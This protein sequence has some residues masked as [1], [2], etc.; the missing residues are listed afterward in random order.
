M[1]KDTKLTSIEIF[2][3]SNKS[4]FEDVYKNTLDYYMKSQ[5]NNILYQNGE[6]CLLANNIIISNKLYVNKYHIIEKNKIKKNKS[7]IKIIVEILENLGGGSYLIKTMQNNNIYKLKQDKSYVV[8]FNLLKKCEIILLNKIIDYNNKNKNETDF[9]SDDK[10]IIDTSEEDSSN[11]SKE[12][13]DLE[14]EEDDNIHSEKLLFR[15]K[16]L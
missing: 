13:T 14:I 7:F 4:I 5:K 3:G 2:F 12:L 9:K 15:S 11:K 8:N 1:D 16:S 6:K 10:E